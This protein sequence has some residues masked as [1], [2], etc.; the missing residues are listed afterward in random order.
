MNSGSVSFSSQYLQR[1]RIHWL[2]LISSQNFTKATSKNRLLQKKNDNVRRVFDCIEQYPIID[3]KRTAVNLKVSYNTISTVVRKL[4]QT[5][6]L[7]EATNAAR[8]RV[9]SYEEY[10]S[11]LRKDI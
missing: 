3:I 11:I 6:I 2:Q 8:N 10:L 5:G 9:F 7:K 4:N 1:Q